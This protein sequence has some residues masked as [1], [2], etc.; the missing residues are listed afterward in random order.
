MRSILSFFFN[1]HE[2]YEFLE[3]IANLLVMEVDASIK[4]K[5]DGPDIRV[6][7]LMINGQKVL[8]INDDPY[9]SFLRAES[10]EEKTV[11]KDLLPK[12]EK[13]FKDNVSM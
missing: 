11:L 13:I 10:N 4:E 9:G 6:W 7:T 3:I 1:M 5:I 12:L 8:L 2:D